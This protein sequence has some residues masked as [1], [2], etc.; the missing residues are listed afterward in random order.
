MHMLGT[1][2]TMQQDPH[3]ADVVTEVKEFLLARARLAGAAGIAGSGSGSI[4]AS[5]SARPWST[6]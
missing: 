2:A 3:Y 5:G 4:R 1:P 6:T